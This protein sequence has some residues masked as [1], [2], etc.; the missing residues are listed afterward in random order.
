MGPRR[1]CEEKWGGHTRE[2][3]EGPQGLEGLSSG[4]ESRERGGRAADGTRGPSEPRGGSVRGTMKVTMWGQQAQR[5]GDTQSGGERRGGK[6]RG[7][8]LWDKVDLC[9]WE[10]AQRRARAQRCQ[11]EC[12][13]SFIHSLTQQVFTTCLYVPSTVLSSRGGTVN[14]RSEKSLPD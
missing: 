10:R 14:G 3:G 6:A 2:H 9:V 1:E 11:G 7:G 12:V 8:L 4:Q 5:A 13:H